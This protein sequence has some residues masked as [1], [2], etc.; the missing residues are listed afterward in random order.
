MRS[1]GWFASC[2]LLCGSMASAQVTLSNSSMVQ[3]S[4][5]ATLK[6][7]PTELRVSMDITGSGK[8]LAEA[9]ASLAKARDAAKAKLT[10]LKPADGSLVVED[11]AIGSGGTG[12]PQERQY[13][14]MMQMRNQGKAKAAAAAS[15]TVSSSI[16]ASFPLTGSGDE[17]LKTSYELQ[18]KIKKELAPADGDKKKLTE[19][20]E[21]MMAEMAM[22]N[23]GMP[24]PGEP[25]FSYVAVLSDAEATKL[26]ADALAKAKAQAEL[27]A[28]A[29]GV[30]LGNLHQISAHA[31]GGDANEYNPYNRFARG[32]GE[33]EAREAT[34]PSAGSVSYTVMVQ[35][36]YELGKK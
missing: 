36:S 7:Q 12:T 11:T 27:I 5:T 4:G 6:K 28:K 13:R 31:S 2:V 14:M 33:G 10:E 8:D 26:T 20:E 21:E 34:S 23:D 24:K 3:A 30:P 32:G 1:L 17:A 35:A 19:E 29:A 25:S 22:A 16:K 9:M 18:E 15:V